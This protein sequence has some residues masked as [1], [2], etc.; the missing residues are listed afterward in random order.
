MNEKKT[1]FVHFMTIMTKIKIMK[2]AKC[3]KNEDKNF[4]KKN[5]QKWNFVNIIN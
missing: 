2:I 3:D 5:V 1:L 4:I